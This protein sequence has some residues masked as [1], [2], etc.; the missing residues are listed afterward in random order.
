MK[1]AQRE[2][3]SFVFLASLLVACFLLITSVFAACSDKKENPPAESGKEVGTYYYDTN[4][5]QNRENQLILTDGLKFTFT[6]E[7]GESHI[8]SYSLSEG[9]LTLTDGEWVQTATYND[10][11]TISLTYNSTQMTFLRKTAYT[12]S[13]DTGSGSK[14][15]AQTV[16]NGRM[17][18]K[19]AD[20]ALN[21]S[22]FLGWFAD[23]AFTTPYSFG[24][25]PIT[26]N[27]T[28]YAR[29][30]QNSVDG[31][32][33]TINYALGYDGAEA[34]PAD[35]T[36][37]GKLYNAATPA[38]RSGYTFGGWWISM[39]NEADRLSYSFEDPDQAS[40]G[41]VFTAD[42]TLFAIWH[43]NAATLS[44]APA[45]NVSQSRAS[46][47]SVSG[48]TSYSVEIIAPDGI[49]D[50]IPTSSTNISVTDRFTQTGVY[51]LSVTALNAGGSAVSETAVRYFVN[52][53]L[54]RV[55]G[56]KVTEPDTLVYR[57]VEGAERYLITI[58]CGNEDHNHVAFNNG[59]SLYY[60]FSNCEMQPG[61]IK[62]TIEAVAE[63]FAPSK[64]TYVFE[65]NLA[66]V[67]GADITEDDVVIWDSVAGASYYNVTVG[68]DTYTT[69]DTSFSLREMPTGE[70]TVSITPV[71]K[72]YNSPAAETVTYEKTAPALPSDIR[73]VDTTLTWTVAPD[74]TYAIVYGNNTTAVTGT[75]GSFDLETLTG[76]TWTDEGRY[77]VQLQVTQG[78][79]SALSDEF[80]FIYNALEPTLTYSGSVLSWKPVAGA[81]E[82]QVSINGELIA[83]ITNGE[84]SLKIDSLAASGLNTIEVRFVNATGALSDPATL[85]VYALA[86][87]FN[88][89]NGDSE[90]LYKAV[91]DELTPPVASSMVGHDFGAWYTTPAGPATNGAVYSS[92]FF[93]GP[94]ELVLYAYYQPKEYT[95][96]FSGDNLGELESGTVTYGQNFSLDVPAA[97]SNGTSAFGGWYS[98]PYGSGIQ[99]TDAYGKSTRT[100]NLTEDNVTLY[101][102]WVDEVLSYQAIGGNYQVSA[103]DRINL[104]QTVTIPSQYN[105]LPVT[106]VSAN[107]FY[108][109]TSITDIYIPDTINIV[110]S[111]AFAGCSSLVNIHV[112]DAGA[113]DPRYESHDGV[114]YDRGID[115][116]YLRPVYMPAAKTGSYT[117]PDGVDQIPANAFKGSGISR[118]VIPQSVTVIGQEAFAN[119]INLATVTFV[120]PSASGQLSVGN[121]AFMNCFSLTN[122]TFPA[123]LSQIATS[124]VND[125]MLGSFSSLDD[126]TA[127]ADDAFLID[128]DAI[129]VEN[130]SDL[131]TQ[132]V[133]VNVA[134]GSGAT[135]SSADGVL[136]RNN[137]SE[138]VYFPAA[139]DAENYAI[140]STT[141]RICES[142]F[143]DTSLSGILT[144]PISVQTID[145]F[146][147]AATDIT[148]VVFKGRAGAA[149]L[150]TGIGAYAFYNCNSLA[151]LTFEENSIV[152]TI[153]EGAFMDTEELTDIT[154]PSTVTEIGDRAFAWSGY[155]TSNYDTKEYVSVTFESA[156]DTTLPELKLGSEVFFGNEI[157]E[158]YIPANAVFSTGFFSGLIPEE[159][160]IS[161]QNNTAAID[162][163]ALFL[164]DANGDYTTLLLFMG[165]YSDRSFNFTYEK[166][167]EGHHKAGDPITTVTEI[168]SGAFRGSSLDSIMIPASVQVIGD[169][170]FYGSDDLDTLEFEK[171]TGSLTIGNYAFYD[172]YLSKIALPDDRNITVGD[173][174]FAYIS[175]YTSVDSIDLGGTTTVGNYAFAINDESYDSHGT[176]TITPSVV[177]IGEGAF[178]GH[179]EYSSN[180]GYSTIVIEE[181]SHLET[182]G[183]YAFADNNFTS[184][185]VPASVT[186]I[187]GFAFDNCTALESLT[188]EEGDKPL[189]FGNPEGGTDRLDYDY[190][191]EPVLGGVSGLTEI[192]FPG[193]LTEL[194][195]YALYDTSSREYG[196][197]GNTIVATSG[198]TTVTFG[199]YSDENT[200][201]YSESTLTTIGNGVLY[202]S[203]ITSLIIPASVTLVEN[204]AFSDSLLS[205]ITFESTAGTP[206]Q[207]VIQSGVFD[208]CD[209]LTAIT[210]PSS[211]LTLEDGVFTGSSYSTL[212]SITVEEGCANYASEDGVLYN[213]DLTELLFCPPAKTEVVVAAET[214]VIAANAFA[215]SKA[216]S[217][218]FETGS[219]L[220]EIGDR[221]FASSSLT[222]IVIP[223]SVTTLGNNVFEY[224]S[225][226]EITLPASLESFNSNIIYGC[227]N[228]TSISINDGINFAVDSENG[229]VF[230]ADRTVL[231]YHI[232]NAAK[233]EYVVPEGVKEI[234]DNAFYND[235]YITKITLPASL[236]RIGNGALRRTAL[237]T[238][239]FTAGG[240][241]ALAIGEY[242]L[243]DNDSLTSIALPARTNA[244]GNN[245]FYDTALTSIT[246]GGE[247]SQLRT[248]GN[249]S[250]YGTA[251]TSVTLPSSVVSIGDYAF[252]RCSNLTTVTLNEG[253]LEIG[254]YAFA[255]QTSEAY[256]DEADSSLETVNL[257]S[258]LTTMGDGIFAYDYALKNVNF[259]ANSQITSLPGT[260][261]EGCTGLESI[262][263]PASLTEISGR[264]R[265]SYGLQGRG[266]FES[267]TALRTVN[268]EEGSKLTTIGNY[269]FAGS[270]LESII[271]PNSVTTIGEYAFA[272]SDPYGTG[273]ML[274]TI[275][276]PRTVTSIGTQAFTRC[277][278]LESVYIDA[279]ITELPGYVFQSCVNLRLISLPA[280]LETIS[281]TAFV[282]CNN[283]TQFI[284]ADGNE[285]YAVEER[286]GGLFNADYTELYMLPAG[287]T[288]FVVPATLEVEDLAEILADYSTITTISVEEG[289]TVYTSLENVVYNSQ[290]WDIVF[291]PAGIKEIELPAAMTTL[292]A[293]TLSVINACTTLEEIR[294]QD[295]ET[296]VTRNFNLKYNVLYTSDWRIM[297]V[298]KA[299]KIFTIP[300]ELTSIEAGEYMFG[301][302]MYGINSS[303]ETIT[304]DKD[305]VRT[306]PFVIGGYRYDYYCPFARME[307]LTSVELPAGTILGQNAFAYSSKLSS[308][309]LTA[310]DSGTI[311]DNAF[312][313]TALTSIVIPEGY[314]SLGS[315]VFSG[316]TL[317]VS[318]PA[319]LTTITTSTFSGCTITG[320]TL[321]E[322][323]TSFR[324]ED[325]VFS[326]F[327]GSTVYFI[328]GDLETFEIS[329]EMTDASSLLSLLRNVGTLK[330]ITVEEGNTNYHAKFGALYDMEWNLLFVPKAMTTFTIPVEV[331]QLGGTSAI[332][333][334]FDGSAITKVTYEEGD[335][336][337]FTVEGYNSSSVFYGANNLTTVELPAR[338]VSIGNYAFYRL[339]N[340]T[341]L[342]YA[343]GANISY[344][345]NYALSRC[346]G[347]SSFTVPTATATEGGYV[348][349]EAFSYWGQGDIE[350]TIIW[351]IASTDEPD[352]LYGWNGYWDWQTGSANNVYT[353]TVTE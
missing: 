145:R 319:S 113:V 45:V 298:P 87:T 223:D 125:N 233:T 137:G 222:S 152:S 352:S 11:E 91:G 207:L 62:F 30:A 177:T 346:Y 178:R 283:I 133:A 79:A 258:T 140:P 150:S 75:S 170:A 273:T 165:G 146:A 74:V 324:Y 121:R 211:L 188:F 286:S 330:E 292:S 189:V 232:P 96:I 269:A 20:P 264:I 196:D 127:N 169:Y 23:S 184:F 225:I 238:V 213:G 209:E 314:T 272:Y 217:V 130:E 182:I 312:Q 310:G 154:I 131:D 84:S 202:G 72:G 136:F 313:N 139:K 220:T 92:P 48:A 138:L 339:D 328:G 69:M 291:L 102:F 171:G 334:L 158:L 122:I 44:A 293:T 60:N 63:G 77:I 57:G 46:W 251:L 55:S 203:A 215:Y 248:I 132:L 275:T 147:F 161:P 53:G 181:G 120:N 226:E 299:L 153:G 263:L 350:Q 191:V 18:S 344:I 114:L 25:L 186:S 31:I 265:D 335:G 214:E 236:T 37:G 290:T 285:Y 10:N 4:G 311:G 33:Y 97:P 51:Q 106:E 345:G 107:A 212:A 166:D 257:P 297:L 108:G 320:V 229:Y 86:V 13:F 38:E 219:K 176:V 54:N 2:K 278:N 243:G 41:T 259:A 341:T 266:L 160:T 194:G 67:T 1:K 15:P 227:E 206:A 99:Y 115:K 9:T 141:T 349:D 65:R 281:S 21:G 98:G 26:A 71:A 274:T 239:V 88:S 195:N 159:I 237:T 35:T 8:G 267:L 193:R 210:L 302:G 268:F 228:I 261:F 284:V 342:T 167:V 76:L 262:T 109:C 163:K 295:S 318:L 323:N 90:T 94:S 105:G 185:N 309:I 28:L 329:A 43:E 317:S 66:A 100:W 50:S 29:W 95:V 3:R 288:E 280:S 173:Y 89:N 337:A 85:E 221:A 82:Y 73:L 256:A 155:E 126:L 199:K 325:Y 123:R 83:T 162:N 183:R 19:P 61:G 24:S 241:E 276:I 112:Y 353:D 231:Y 143:L 235:S 347:I 270:G 111:S 135:Y 52:N 296:P 303:I 59:T 338:T 116:T 197:D 321:A 128:K 40:G 7:N 70:Y 156:D 144:I 315:N 250:F 174:A 192:H 327:D 175:D 27:T 198:L 200:E 151:E 224:S 47:N 306:E 172:T 300:A 252:Y 336:E 34:I 93:N 282:N 304:Y 58:D 253:L 129:E 56:V 119:C 340:I 332:S 22:T 124:R 164:K 104:V 101:A 245:A 289:N 234:G 277:E 301:S 307:N 39:E 78:N 32:E 117:I 343:E 260:T 247:N 322:G 36:V 168:A 249:Y 64:T 80:T 204:D 216:T 218:T 148:E 187:A 351:P 308:V 230:N 208:E 157:D 110:P 246:F 305:T 42:T 179:G 81:T 271:I 254:D 294:I 180:Y 287:I 134:R 142:A 16:I 279:N 242:A 149:G 331:T 17:A 348:G 205:D 14:I 68:E 12:V 244:I 103:G 326:S 6:P 316:L 118:V 333:G 190:P 240:T 5:D 255:A 49:S 201:N